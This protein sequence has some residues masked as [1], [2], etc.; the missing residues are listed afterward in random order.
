[1]HLYVVLPMALGT[2]HCDKAPFL[3]GARV[4]CMRVGVYRA[5]IKDDK[6]GSGCRFQGSGSRAPDVIAST[7]VSCEHPKATCTL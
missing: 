7:L 5:D 2:L 6:S 1:M 3:Q 4:E